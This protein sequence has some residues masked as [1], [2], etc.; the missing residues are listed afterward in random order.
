MNISGPAWLTV[1]VTWVTRLT[2]EVPTKL[3]LGDSLAV[4]AFSLLLV[5]TALAAIWLVIAILGRV[6]RQFQKP[7]GGA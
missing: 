5:F 2:Y 4:T 6:L 7:R 1:L 3:D